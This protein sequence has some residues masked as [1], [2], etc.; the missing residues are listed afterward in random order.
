MPK[1]SWLLS[2]LRH[3]CQC[4]TPGSAHC[5]L[6]LFIKFEKY[7][8][9]LSHVEATFGGVAGCPSWLPQGKGAASEVFAWLRPITSQT[10]LWFFLQS[11]LEAFRIIEMTA[12]PPLFWSQCP[13][14]PEARSHNC[15]Y[16]KKIYTKNGLSRNV[17]FVWWE[18]CLTKGKDLTTTRHRL[19]CQRTLIF[20][21][22]STYML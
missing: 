7:P 4:R 21:G 5:Q 16:T 12:A 10:S 22:P 15:I 9:E 6:A 13:P 20:P 8:S 3:P 11:V 19:D 2:W 14:P 18:M 17:Q 1:P